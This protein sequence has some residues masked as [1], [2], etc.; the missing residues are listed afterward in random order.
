MHFVIF[1]LFLIVALQQRNKN[2]KARISD[3]SRK[4]IHDA[5]SD[6]ITHVL[7]QTT[8]RQSQLYQLMYSRNYT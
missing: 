6:V 3:L 8:L 2:S 7:I 4:Q 1:H 5:T